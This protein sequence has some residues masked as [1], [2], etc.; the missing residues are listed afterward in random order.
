MDDDIEDP[1]GE[2]VKAEF[3]GLNESFQNVFVN[4]NISLRGEATK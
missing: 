3:T 4:P 1:F 2:E